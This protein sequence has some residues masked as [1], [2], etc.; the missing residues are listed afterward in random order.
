MG[1]EETGGVSGKKMNSHGSRQGFFPEELGSEDSGE[2]ES[3]S[4]ASLI[5]WNSNRQKCSGMSYVEN[6]SRI[7]SSIPK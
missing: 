5:L 4:S 7:G 3:D 2:H 6:F 1:D